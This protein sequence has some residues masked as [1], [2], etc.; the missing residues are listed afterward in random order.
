MGWAPNNSDKNRGKI[1][2]VV[3]SDDG[4]FDLFL[5]KVPLRSGVAEMWLP[6]I[7]CRRYG[8]CADE[9][10]AI[11]VELNQKGRIT[12]RFGS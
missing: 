10:E 3:K 2:E 9:Y 4:T 5:N 6:D 11:L 12:L 8:Y 1:L 7:L